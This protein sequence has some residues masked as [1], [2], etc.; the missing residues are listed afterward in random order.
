MA[1]EISY[2]TQL[3][4][5]VSA[6]SVDHHFWPLEHFLRRGHLIPSPPRFNQGSS[7]ERGLVNI[8]KKGTAYIELA[9]AHNEKSTLCSENIIA[10]NATNTANK[11]ESTAYDTKCTA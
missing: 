4:C 5:Q 7:S 1:F 9:T 6:K 8:P 11:E 2:H 3:L 10:Q